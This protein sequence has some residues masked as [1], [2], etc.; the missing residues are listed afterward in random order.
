MSHILTQY[1]QALSAPVGRARERW[2]LRGYHQDQA[3]G[4]D[5]LEQIAVYARAGYF[6]MGYTVDAFYAHA[7]LPPH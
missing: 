7:D 2:R 6:N 3:S 4:S 1:W 5:R